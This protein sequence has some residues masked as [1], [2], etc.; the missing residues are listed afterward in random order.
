M[1]IVVIYDATPGVQ[2]DLEIREALGIL[3][4]VRDI[5]NII[6]DK[7][8][9]AD[10]LGF[11]FPVIKSVQTLLN[12]KPDLVFNLC[13]GL[14]DDSSFEINVASLL[15]FFGLAFT[16]SGPLSLSLCHNKEIAK[17]QLSFHGIPTPKHVLI[18][19][20]Q[21]IVRNGLEYPLIVKPV[22]EDGSFGIDE[23]SVVISDE[24]LETKVLS[25][26]RRFRQGAMVEEFI[27]GREFNVSILGN[28]PFDFVQIR[29]IQFSEDCKPRIISFK[30]KWK[31]S[32]LAY[33]ATS[34][35]EV[36]HLSDRIQKRILKYAIQCFKIFKMRDYGRIDFRLGKSEVPYVIDLNPNPCIS[37]DSGMVMAAHQN[38]MS[39]EELIGRI[40]SCAFA[41][42]ESREGERSHAS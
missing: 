3:K 6:K 39:Y 14:G 32:S 25:V 41:R 31:K 24:A 33:Q 13:E 21:K 9:R 5:E 29:E 8:L 23:D 15:E 22:H 42:Y 26:H 36:Q 7:G 17:A 16:G 28:D 2:S 1:K 20:G 12:Q 4:D 18:E 34:T 37:R 30:S 19:Q 11:E 40:T 10:I 27:D 35:T 38:G